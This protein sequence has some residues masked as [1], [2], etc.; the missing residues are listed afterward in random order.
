MHRACTLPGILCLHSIS[1]VAFSGSIVLLSP[2]VAFCEVPSHILARMG[3]CTG[4][5]ALCM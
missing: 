5:H 2:T 3:G 1:V 4:V